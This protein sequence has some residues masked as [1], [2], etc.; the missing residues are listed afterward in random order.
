MV[1]EA[2]RASARGLISFRGALERAF[3]SHGNLPSGLRPLALALG[4]AVLRRYKLLMRA[5]RLVKGV[6]VRSPLAWVLAYEAMFRDDV[7]VNRLLEI[8]RRRNLPLHRRDLELLR[9]LDVSSVLKGLSGLK[10][11]SV[12]YSFPLWVVA[13]LVRVHGFSEARS[14]LE[15][16]NKPHPRWVWIRGDAAKVVEMLRREGVLLKLDDE[17]RDVGLLLRGNLARTSA[18]KMALVLY[19]DKS[20][21][22]AVHVLDP[23]PGERILDACSAPGGKA[24]HAYHLAAGSVTIVAS[25][26]SINRLREERKLSER[27]GADLL[28]LNADSRQPPLRRAF[29]KAIVDPDCSSLGKLGHSPEIRLWLERLGEGVVSRLAARQ[30]SI[31]RASAARVKK[32][33]TVVYVTCTLTPEEN[34]RV[35]ERA[36]NEGLLEPGEVDRYELC[37]KYCAGGFRHVLKLLPHKHMCIGTFIAKLRVV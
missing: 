36:V 30:L 29:D 9:N 11:L 25:D 16:M 8:S 14:M 18:Y 6:E 33:G 20:S 17:L 12:R 22:M 1:A 24:L 35:I 4:L 27:L 28:L 21:V 5:L 10:L 3:R 13:R 32:G 31:L 7:S 37:T 2:I 15:A 19:R 23:K 34:E 26:I